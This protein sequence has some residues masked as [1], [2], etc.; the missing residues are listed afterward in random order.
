MRAIFAICAESVA[1]D[2]ATNRLS[3]FHIL[4]RLQATSFPI[5]V[6]RLTFIAMFERQPSEPSQ[7]DLELVVE[8]NG[9]TLHR[10]AMP[11]DYQGQ[12]ATRAI[13]EMSGLPLPSPGLVRIVALQQNVEMAYWQIEVANIGQLHL[14]PTSVPGIGTSVPAPPPTPPKTKKSVRTAKRRKAS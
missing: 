13:V 6:P 11:V 1:I 4:E 9:T 10:G 8:L 14:T 12:A 5:L 2:G 7:F 3:I